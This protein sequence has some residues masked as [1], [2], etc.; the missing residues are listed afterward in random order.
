MEPSH[1][2]LNDALM[3]AALYKELLIQDDLLVS[4]YQATLL[5]MNNVPRPIK[6]IN[7]QITKMMVK[8]VSKIL[9]Y[10]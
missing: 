1:D 5:R 9:I 3:L 6:K 8:L 10:M 2:P 7:Q 4:H